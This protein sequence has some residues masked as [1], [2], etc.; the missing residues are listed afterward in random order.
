M[1]KSLAP[2]VVATLAGITA[3]ALSS[4]AAAA[5]PVRPELGAG[6]HRDRSA[7]TAGDGERLRPGAPQPKLP[8]SPPSEPQEG[9]SQGSSATPPAAE[10]ERAAREADERKA[11]EA[12]EKMKKK[13]GYKEEVPS[14][15]AS[16]DASPRSN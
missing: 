10:N 7:Q 16:G 15:R 2:A 3:A 1:R 9:A 4:I 5:D 12:K 11:T 14:P 8:E 6:P 13:P